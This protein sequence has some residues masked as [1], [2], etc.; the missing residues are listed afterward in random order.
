[1]SLKKLFEEKTR[2]RHLNSYHLMELLAE[3]QKNNSSHLQLQVELNKRFSISLATIAFALIAIPLGITAHRKETSVGFALS[4][5]IA[6][7][8]FFFII[9]A[10]TFRSNPHAHP[11]VLIWL[12]N[13]IFTG[14]GIFLFRRLVKR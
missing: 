4:L 13:I 12:P 8:Y 14:L 6:F 11:I 5:A 2:W 1:M 3:I 9:I 7:G 10:D